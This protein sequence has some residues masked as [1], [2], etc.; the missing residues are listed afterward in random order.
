[1]KCALCGSEIPE[2][3]KFCP[4]CGESVDEEDSTGFMIVT[5]PTVPGYRITK[6]FG[7]VTG[8]TPRTRGIL[9]KFVAGFESMFGGEVTAFTSELEKARLDAIRR[10]RSKALNLGANAVVGLDLETSDLGLQLG[11][12]VISATGTAVVIEKE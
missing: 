7:V 3:A 8:L 12:V 11:V 2:D 1:M 9:G 4:K 5:T 6:V 10:V